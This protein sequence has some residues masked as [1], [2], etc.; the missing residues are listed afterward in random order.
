MITKQE[1]DAIIQH[2]KS[3]H[4][5]SNPNSFAVC[6]SCDISG[7]FCTLNERGRCLECQVDDDLYAFQG[8]GKLQATEAN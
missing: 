5:Y 7:C 2:A 8:K 4:D 6:Q 3:D 1:A